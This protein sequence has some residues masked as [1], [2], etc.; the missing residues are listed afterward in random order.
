MLVPTFISRG[1]CVTVD[2]KHGYQWFYLSAADFL[3]FSFLIH[4]PTQTT[5]PPP[6]TLRPLFQPTW[7]GDSEPVIRGSAQ[8]HSASRQRVWVRQWRL[9]AHPPAATRG[10]SGTHSRPDRRDAQV[11]LWVLFYLHIRCCI[12]CEMLNVSPLCHFPAASCAAQFLYILNIEHGWIPL[13]VIL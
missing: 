7:A 5:N 11:L 4:K 2:D 1:Q 9:A 12:D 3:C 6:L 10:R 8:L 13:Y